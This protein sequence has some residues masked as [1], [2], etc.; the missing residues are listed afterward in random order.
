[1][2]LRTGARSSSLGADVPRAELRKVSTYAGKSR[3]KGAGYG[4]LAGAA[5]GAAAFG[6]LALADDDL[7]VSPALVIAAGALWFGGAGAVVGLVI[8]AAKTQPIYEVKIP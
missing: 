7:D 3:G 4:A 1:M 5:A 2:A 6:A 8:G